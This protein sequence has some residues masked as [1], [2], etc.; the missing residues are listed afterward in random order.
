MASHEPQLAEPAEDTGLGP[1][2]RLR[3]ARER[4]ELAVG[5]VADALHLQRRI[6][7]A[8]EADR[9]D[10][11]PPVTF[12][13]GYLRSYARLVEVP[14]EEILRAYD[15]LG[16]REPEPALTQ[17][18]PPRRGPASGPSLAPWLVAALAVA[19]IGGGAWFWVAERGLP[20]DLLARLGGAG[21]TPAAGEDVDASGGEGNAAG[22]PD[23]GST[24]DGALSAAPEAPAAEPVP[25]EP[26]V[27]ADASADT[28]MA[29]EIRR[30]ES[31]AEREGDAAVDTEESI[32]GA[33]GP[34]GVEPEGSQSAETATAARDG[35][36]GDQAA[37]AGTAPEAET[38]A[39]VETGDVDR[40]ATAPDGGG[41]E[42]ATT[43]AEEALAAG[44]GAAE[45][46]AATPDDG[47][48]TE[49]AGA[50]AET[51]AVGG[52]G[53]TLE[54]RFSGESWMEVTD[55]RGERLLFGLI[56]GGESHSVAGEPPFRIVIGDVQA[57]TLRYDGNPVALNERASGRVA[58]FTLGE[59]P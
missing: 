22:S 13:R 55:A 50:S 58:R 38:P 19:V 43:G 36:R 42:E 57:V 4:R 51:P 6:V 16:H 39:D 5:A 34:G 28:G 44:G 59:R 47:A 29:G 33:E 2:R 17:P 31:I 18:A 8:I 15:R 32:A 40:S 9:Y 56:Q 48:E 7:E 27:G 11:L 25:A 53:E 37:V 45:P 14:E 20:D 30:Q 41:G 10:E 12:T 3:L 35:D 54:F 1:G 23:G 26:E 49:G 21:S 52:P 24:P 46:G